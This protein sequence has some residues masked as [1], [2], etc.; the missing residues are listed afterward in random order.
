MKVLDDHQPAPYGHSLSLTSEG[1]SERIKVDSLTGNPKKIY[2][3]KNPYLSYEFI[4]EHQ[5]SAKWTLTNG[6]QE[7]VLGYRYTTGPTWA[8]SADATVVLSLS[9]M[10]DLQNKSI[11]ELKSITAVCTS[12]VQMVIRRQVPWF[13]QFKIGTN[14]AAEWG[15]NYL[16][17]FLA[18]QPFIPKITWDFVY[19]FDGT[20]GDQ[21]ARV[22]HSVSMLASNGSEIDASLNPI[23]PLHQMP[24]AP[25]CEWERLA[26]PTSPLPK[27]DRVGRGKFRSFFRLNF[28]KKK[29]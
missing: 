27:T 4:P 20:H 3:D 29:N 8:I 2:L 15:C 16:I 18:S 24:S 28:K 25:C 10:F 11:K 19:N 26:P 14:A 1:V 6:A 22:T 5:E 17:H 9:T 12:T 23:H 7:S 13:G 21:Q